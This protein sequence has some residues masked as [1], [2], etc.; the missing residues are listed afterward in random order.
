MLSV[1]TTHPE[2]RAALQRGAIAYLTK[3]FELK[4]MTRLVGQI[5]AMDGT[6]RDAYRQK[7]L[8][9]LEI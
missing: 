5:L 6:K 1:V 9:V 7:A 4:E 3:P 2:V 8:K